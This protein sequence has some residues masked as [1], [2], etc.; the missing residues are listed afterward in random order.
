MLER[1]FVQL[2]KDD[3]AATLCRY[4][5]NQVVRNFLVVQVEM[6]EA[7]VKNEEIRGIN[8][9]SQDRGALS[10][11]IGT[12]SGFF[13]QQGDNAQCI[14]VGFYCGFIRGIFFTESAQHDVFTDGQIRNEPDVLKKQ[15]YAIFSESND[16]FNRLR[17]QFHIAK[18][19]AAIVFKMIAQ[20]RRSQR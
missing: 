14:G 13:L 19:D 15:L 17:L 7:F 9:A 5:H 1:K 4:F 6:A 2:K 3:S 18:T 16:L 8:Q 10:F 20:H 12:V 11:T